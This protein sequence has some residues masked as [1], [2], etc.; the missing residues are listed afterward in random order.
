MKDKWFESEATENPFP[1]GVGVSDTNFLLFH[2]STKKDTP[3]SAFTQRPLKRRPQQIS[4]FIPMDGVAFYA[5]GAHT[6]GDST[7][8]EVFIY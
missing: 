1:T 6:T 7:E 2:T 5:S 8:R 3:R 4:P